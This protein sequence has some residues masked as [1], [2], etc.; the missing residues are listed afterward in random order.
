MNCGVLSDSYSDRVM[1]THIVCVGNAV[2]YN[3]RVGVSVGVLNVGTNE[4]NL[5][6]AQRHHERLVVR[7][8]QFDKHVRRADWKRDLQLKMNFA[9]DHH[10]R[11]VVVAGQIERYVVDIHNRLRHTYATA[12]TIIIIIIMFICTVQ[13]AIY[14]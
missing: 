9:C 12:I 13:F 6:T 3:S 11:S 5:R 2:Q 7:G 10:S 14:N 1:G 4:R 8:E